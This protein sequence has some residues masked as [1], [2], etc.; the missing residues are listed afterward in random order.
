MHQYGEVQTVSL[1]NLNTFVIQYLHAEH[2]YV[3]R[4][5]VAVQIVHEIS[6][7]FL[8]YFLLLFIVLF[9]IYIIFPFHSS[10]VLLFFFDEDTYPREWHSDD[11]QTKRNP[12]AIWLLSLPWWG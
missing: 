9:I 2:D 12:Q 1:R 6:F 4:S 10:I 11:Q 3:Y 7:N 8:N 5:P